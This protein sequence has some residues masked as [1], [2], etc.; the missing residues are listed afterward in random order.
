[1][2]K[3]NKVELL[4]PNN[5]ALERRSRA[6][7]V[8][9]E[10]VEIDQESNL[11]NCWRVLRNR[12]WTILVVLFLVFALTAIWTAR[13]R[14]IFRANALLEIEKENPDILTV[15]DLFA[16][17][18]VSDAYLETEYKILKS[19]SLAMRVIDQL[20][21]EFGPKTSSLDSSASKP[22]PS[23]YER[24]LAKFQDRL[25]VAPIR[26][27]RLVAIS[28]DSQD[29]ILAAH[30]V[31]SL[32]FDYI[33]Q[34]RKNRWD[35]TQQASEY[36]SR[37]LLD[38]KAKL[39]ASEEEL[40]KYATQNSLIFLQTNS[41][42]T[43][44]IV[45]ERLR[46]LQEELTRA[47]AARYE[48]ESLYRLV[49]GEDYA[50]L[51]GVFENKL[52]QDLTEQLADLQRQ[53]AQLSTNFSPSY[54]RAKQVQDQVKE[55]EAVLARE[56]KHAAQKITDDYF[57]AVNREKLVRNDFDKQQAQAT[58]IAQ[59]SVQYN[60]LKREVD[61][62]KNLYESLLQRRKEADVLAGLK[63]GNIRIVDPG[64]PPTKPVIPNVPLNLAMGIVVG[65]TFGIALAFL[66]ECRDKSV[67]NPEVAERFLHM[68]VL[69]IVPRLE[70]L[71]RG[72]SLALS[73]HEATKSPILSCTGGQDTRTVLA[74]KYHRIDNQ[75]QANPALLEAFRGLCTSVL[76]S[77]DP[78][79]PGSILITS[80]Q[81]S[82]GKTTVASNLAIS[83]AALG[84]RVLLVDA[85]MR[86]P[87]L[88]E[89]FKISDP[90]ERGLASYLA[91][92][93]D[94]RSTVLHSKSK[95]LDVLLG[96]A[97]PSNSVELLFS[98]DRM[99]A[100]ISESMREYK[101]VI[102]DSPPLMTVADSR[103]LAA[104]V[105]AVI[106]VIRSGATPLAFVQQAEC[107]LRAVRANVIGIIL[108]N[109]RLDRDSY[110]G[111]YGYSYFKPRDTTLE[112]T[113]T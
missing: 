32:A 61:T 110:Y 31:N 84:H 109:I 6:L 76:L 70:P 60:I 102:I 50:S 69:G 99:R 55:L 63:A 29:P 41:S 27:S 85:D 35:T 68:P 33:E 83:L 22:D 37:Q 13:Q 75:G 105:E 44:N 20:G 108:N 24:T 34:D 45:N 49:Q 51:P 64:I 80:T 96:G 113:L 56:R 23:A 47:Q 94:W 7:P 14:T 82:E 87:S 2:D 16:V 78:H 106:L 12:R 11:L 91:C 21:P 25:A 19:D 88:H 38:L 5:G 36:L 103:I 104:L 53:Y 15:Q 90:S 62:N 98:S 77:T 8:I 97:V 71:N 107:Q 52:M 111:R 42:D 93:M 3:E 79:P 92:Q 46:Q 17:D 74:A 43:E 9:P 81:P 73:H 112:P 10:I 48:K 66:Q 101:F 67:K 65:F 30:V 26:R 86:K 89:I 58:L 18:N 59:R 1:M 57:A 100:L 40:Q 72:K 28:F 54:P 4:L 39:E 95:G